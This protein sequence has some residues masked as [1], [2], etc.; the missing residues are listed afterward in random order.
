M[1][2][3]N[4]VVLFV[5][6]RAVLFLTGVTR[7]PD[8]SLKAGDVENGA[9]RFEVRDGEVL[10]KDYQRRIRNRWQRPHYIEVP[11]KPEWRGGYNAVMAKAQEEYDETH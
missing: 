9:W 6:G 2:P 4:R 1:K 10:A 3:T 5:G 8:G 7:N 11:V